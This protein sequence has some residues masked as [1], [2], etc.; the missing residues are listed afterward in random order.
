MDLVKFEQALSKVDASVMNLWAE[1]SQILKDFAIAV[2]TQKTGGTTTTD[3]TA[4]PT[5]Q[6]QLEHGLKLVRFV[7][8]LW[9]LK[10]LE[11]Q[12]LLIPRLSSPQWEQL[13]RALSEQQDP[14]NPE[15]VYLLQTLYGQT[16]WK[17]L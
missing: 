13:D 12:Q 17:L 10:R 5:Y 4:V 14:A 9:L 1:V 16:R 7:K 6:K 8:M 15:Q 3:T 11:G 2:A